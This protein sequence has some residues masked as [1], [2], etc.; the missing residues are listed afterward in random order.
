MANNIDSPLKGGLKRVDMDARLN[1]IHAPLPVRGASRGGP[2]AQRRAHRVQALLTA[3]A[4]RTRPPQVVD[5]AA[6]EAQ[7]T[8][9]AAKAAAEQQR[10]RCER[11][12]LGRALAG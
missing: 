5:K 10:E 11:L 2:Q 4:L 6:L 3:A 9:K 8:E 7:I 12:R 1:A